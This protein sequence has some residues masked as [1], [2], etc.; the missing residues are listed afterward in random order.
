MVSAQ[1]RRKRLE[2]LRKR[3]RDVGAD[4]TDEAPAPKQAPALRFRNYVPEADELVKQVQTVKDA[5]KEIFVPSTT[6]TETKRSRRSFDDFL[7]D[8]IKASKQTQSTEAVL[9]VNARAVDWDLEHE[10][11]DSLDELQARTDAAIARIVLRQQ[12]IA[13]EAAEEE[14]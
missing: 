1:E 13:A 12:E 10:M 4:V 8:A 6:G 11:R 7:K 3:A 5:E 9:A 2:L 14:Q